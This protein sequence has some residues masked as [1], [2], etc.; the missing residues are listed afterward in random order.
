MYTYSQEF[1]GKLL[2]WIEFQNFCNN[3]YK[4]HQSMELFHT[5]HELLLHDVF[6]VENR[7]EIHFKMSE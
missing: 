5:F 1:L 7:K 4:V 3:S 2:K 6:S